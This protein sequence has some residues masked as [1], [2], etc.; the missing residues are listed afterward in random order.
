MC[1]RSAAWLKPVSW[2][3]PLSTGPGPAAAKRS[4]QH[5]RMPAMNQRIAPSGSSPVP[6]H[7]SVN[8][9]LHLPAVVRDRM[10]CAG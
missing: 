7:G 3:T 5:A 1:L 9:L 4:A 2:K 6:G 8:G 10:L